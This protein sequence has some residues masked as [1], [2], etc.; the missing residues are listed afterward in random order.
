VKT[1][2]FDA[3]FHADLLSAFDLRNAGDY[4]VHDAVSRQKAEKTIEQAR[5][6]RSAV[7]AFVLRQG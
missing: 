4:G 7:E 3:R 1:G 5:E 6:I 2:L